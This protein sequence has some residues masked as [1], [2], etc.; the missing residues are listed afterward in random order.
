[1]VTRA[2]VGE[3]RKNVLIAQQSETESF[4]EGRNALVAHVRP[5]LTFTR[6]TNVCLSAFGKRFVVRV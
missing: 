6:Y 3:N 2:R 1:M 5:C 4:P